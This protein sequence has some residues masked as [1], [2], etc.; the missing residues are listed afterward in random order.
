MIHK[1]PVDITYN[2]GHSEVV[3]NANNASL[4]QCYQIPYGHELITKANFANT[5][6]QKNSNTQQ[7]I[8][9]R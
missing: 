8:H 9:N 1:C 6:R 4:F 7:Q 5:P 3:M 2:L